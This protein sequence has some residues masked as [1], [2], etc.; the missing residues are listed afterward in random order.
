MIVAKAPTTAW[1]IIEGE[2]VILSMETKVLRGLNPVG[3]RVWELIDGRRDVEEIIEEIVQEFDVAAAEA[4]RDVMGF[5]Q[6]LLDRGLVTSV[7]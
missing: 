4:G 5:I 3:S 2:A 6:E 7:G 1:R